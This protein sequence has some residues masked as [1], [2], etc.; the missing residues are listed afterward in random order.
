MTAISTVLS[1]IMLPLNLLLYSQF[2]YDADVTSKLDWE[3]LFVSLIVVLSAITL[4]LYCSSRF[5]SEGFK[6]NVNMLGNISGIALVVFSVLLSGS[7]DEAGL[8]SRSSTFYIGVAAPCVLGLIVANIITSQ[9]QLR[10]PERVTVSIECC[11]QNVGIATSVALTMF[12]GNELAEAMGVPLYYGMVEAL[13]LGIY[14]VIAWKAGWTKAPI[15]E[16]FM[17]VLT[18]SYELTS[19]E[20]EI[21]V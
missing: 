13:V 17:T 2:V 3:A 7:D 1:T 9:Y 5:D 14:C 15:N 6:Q 20:Y 18:T 10:K 19:P 21:V 8:W 12:K 4:G 16:N 11:Y